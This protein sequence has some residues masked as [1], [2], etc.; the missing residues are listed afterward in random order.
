MTEADRAEAAV[1]LSRVTGSGGNNL[2]GSPGEQRKDPEEDPLPSLSSSL[3]REESDHNKFYESRMGE[4]RESVPSERTD[5][6]MHRVRARPIH[7]D[8][9]H[10]EAEAGT[11]RFQE[12]HSTW[13]E[14]RIESIVRSRQ[15]QDEDSLE[16]GDCSSLG[17]AVR[18]DSFF[19]NNPGTG[20]RSDASLDQ[21]V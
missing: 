13:K 14:D 9:I 10:G 3:Q 2:I 15:Y 4:D 18:Q 1:L 19:G 5:S 16:T 20:R 11:S 7:V 6:L 17:S 12:E 21:V 8:L